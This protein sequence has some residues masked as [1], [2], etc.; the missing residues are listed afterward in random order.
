MQAI[1]YV[2]LSGL[3]FGTSLIASRFALN[4]FAPVTFTGLRLALASLGFLAL[5]V[6]GR[7]RNPWPSN[8]LL[9]RHALL[10]GLCRYGLADP[11]HGVG[12]T[13]SIQR[14][15]CHAGHGGPGHHRAACPFSAQR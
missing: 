11:G 13:I 1:P 5:Y 6:V 12:P 8:R 7:R 9:W 4:E 3:L 14:C 10:L 15:D 2:L